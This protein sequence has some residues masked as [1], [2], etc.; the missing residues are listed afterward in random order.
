MNSTKWLIGWHLMQKRKDGLLL[1][2]ERLAPDYHLEMMIK[3][4]MK[5]TDTSTAAFQAS[6]TRTPL[7][8]GRLK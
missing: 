4:S 1:L 7:P 3:L 6:I 2:T 8:T 5:S